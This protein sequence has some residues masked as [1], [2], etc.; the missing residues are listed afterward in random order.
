MLLVAFGAFAEACALV[1]AR[2]DEA[3][4]PARR[5]SAASPQPAVLAQGDDPLEPPM[6]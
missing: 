6:A 3:G 1:L 2:G 5:R 4:D